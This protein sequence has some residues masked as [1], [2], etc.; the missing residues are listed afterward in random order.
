MYKMILTINTKEP[1]VETN[2]IIALKSISPFNNI[3]Q[4][5]DA[6]PPGQQ[7]Y[8]NR[9]CMMKRFKLKLYLL[10]LLTK[11]STEGSENILTQENAS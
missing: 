1:R 5:F 10:K 7:P 2:V 3:V 11:A 6:L 8:M 4:L 9:A